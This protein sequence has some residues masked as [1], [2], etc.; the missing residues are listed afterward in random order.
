MTSDD[1]AL[2]A[3]PGIDTAE[4]AAATET[5]EPPASLEPGEGTA[6]DR[7]SRPYAGWMVVARKEFTD[8][9]LSIRFIVLVLVL[10]LAAFVPLFFAAQRIGSLASSVSGEP[11]VFLA[12]FFITSDPASSAGVTVPGVVDFLRLF[13]PLLG[14]AFAFDAV[15][16]ERSEGTLPRLL[17]Q[18]IH[19]DDVINGKFA[20]GLAVI[21]L[22]IAGVLLFVAG[23]GIFR[24]GIIP[25]PTE[26]LRLVVWIFVTL[27][28]VSLWLAFGMMLSVLVRSAATSALIGFGSWFVLTFFGSFIVSFIAGA[29]APLSDTLAS[30]NPDQYLANSSLRDTLFR[31]LPNTLYGESS[32]V[33]LNPTRTSISSLPASV[34]QAVQAQQQIGSLLSLDQSFIIVWPQV[35]ALVALTV[36][37]FGVAY[38]RFMRQEVRA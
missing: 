28:Y 19:R 33:L 24:I 5:G 34:D 3:G 17:S 1:V 12:L 15:N 21:G 35:V 9:L 14:I 37:C 2:P 31:F 32:V 29:V 8:H 16:G 20:S 6:A 30:T 23:V 18:P 11:A 25:A 13:A 38:V 22:V 36:L 7:W 10:G 4:T 27:I 26:V